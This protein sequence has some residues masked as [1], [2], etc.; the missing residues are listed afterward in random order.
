LTNQERALEGRVAIV[1]GGG[2]GLGRATAHLFA[3]HGADLVLAG[4]RVDPLERTASE[5]E[6]LGRR[7]LVAPADV[8]DSAQCEQV[9]RSAVV[10]YGRLD[11]L[12]NNAGG[13]YTKLP[14]DD[15]TP[16]EWNQIIAQNLSSVWFMSRPAAKE[17]IARGKGPSSTSRRREARPRYQSKR[18]TVQ[19]RP[20]STA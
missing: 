12:V 18:R 3:R 20:A 5:I 19:P 17:M 9:V 8:T 1:T 10:E 7:A 13:G 6:N 14:D 2:T 16:D 11:V 15:W 4:R